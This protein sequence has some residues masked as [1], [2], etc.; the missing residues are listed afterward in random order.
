MRYLN[1]IDLVQNELQNAVVQNLAQ[2]PASGELGQIY[3]NTTDKKMYVCVDVAQQTWLPTDASQL[4]GAAIVTRINGSTSIIDMDNLPS[5]NSFLELIKTVDGSGSGL[6]AD[7]VDAHD[8]TW[9]VARANHT[10]TQLAATISDFSTAVE[11]VPTVADAISRVHTQNTD[12]GTTNQSFQLQSGSAGARLKNSGGELQVR[13]AADNAYAD[14]RV[15]NLT[16]EGTLTAIK[17]EEVDIGDSNI[18]LNADVTAHTQNSD[19]GLSIKRL[20]NDDIT[21]KDASIIF[22]NSTGRW[23]TTFGAVTGTLVTAG[24]ANKISALVGNAVDSVYEITHNLNTQDLIVSIMDTES[25]EHVFTDVEM[26]TSAGLSS[27]NVIT[28]RFAT[29]ISQDKYKVT[30]IG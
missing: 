23:Q 24:I 11:A 26:K 17:S 4:T 18:L 27:M 13:N 1:N 7:T 14:I 15:M 19:G 25:L 22:N 10:G 29:V 20:A 3:F 9:L 6:D 21:R 30:I 12:T 5:A 28:L 2:V 16:V 8:S